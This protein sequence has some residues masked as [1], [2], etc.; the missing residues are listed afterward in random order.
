MLDQMPFNSY[1][2]VLITALTLGL[3]EMLILNAL[4]ATII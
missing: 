2:I 3:S 1:C 4:H